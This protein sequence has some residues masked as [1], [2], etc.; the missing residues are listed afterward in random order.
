MNLRIFI[1]CLVFSSHSYASLQSDFQERAESLILKK[2]FPPKKVKTAILFIE[3]KIGSKAESTQII[4]SDAFQVLNNTQKF[5]SYIDQTIFV[6]FKN[7]T[8]CRA[9][10]E[11]FEN[12]EIYNGL[13]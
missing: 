2:I 1:L 7:N 3:K 11:T 13:A 8:I 5:V 9:Q 6:K 12:R 10:L 4:E